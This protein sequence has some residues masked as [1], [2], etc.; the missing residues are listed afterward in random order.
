MLFLL[1]ALP[2]NLVLLG[3]FLWYTSMPSPRAFAASFLAAGAALALCVGLALVHYQR[4]VRGRTCPVLVTAT[5][6]AA[7]APLP[8]HPARARPVPVMGGVRAREER[9]AGRQAG[10]QEVQQDN[11]PV[12]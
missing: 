12:S 8:L 2:L 1:I 4:M 11:F 5:A 3:L 10:R 7:A 6:C 9:P